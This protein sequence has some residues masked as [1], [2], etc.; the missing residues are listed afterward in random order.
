[1]YANRLG[2]FT[3][4]DPA[5]ASADRSLPQS[6]NRYSYTIN[7]PLKFI[8]PSGMIWGI[9]GNQPTWYDSLE[10]LQKAGATIY[11]PTD[12]QYRDGSGNL[13]QFD[14]ASSDWAYVSDIE[15]ADLELGQAVIS[16]LG[17]I[18]GAEPFDTF[19][20]GMSL[21]R[22]NLGD[23]A[24]DMVGN[25]GPLTGIVLAKRLN[26]EIWGIQQC[27]NCCYFIPL[28]GAFQNDYGGCTNKKSPFDKQVMFEHDGCDFHEP[29]EDY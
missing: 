29:V 16:G 27:F 3:T 11:A 20:A 28:S 25:L 18:P 6:W 15:Q 19:N 24:L 23:A 22:G 21:G 10:Q 26:K 1:M 17:M 7:N 12:Y 14:P 2:R 4:V 13:V 5:L 8:D 9:I